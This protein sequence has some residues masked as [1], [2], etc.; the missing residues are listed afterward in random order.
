MVADW[1][2][3]II[4]IKLN[5]N[6]AIFVEVVDFIRL[7]C[8]RQFEFQQRLARFA[9]VVQ[10]DAA[11][12][13]LAGKGRRRRRD[14]QDIEGSILQAIILGDGQ[15]QQTEAAAD[16]QNDKDQER[17][18]AQASPLLAEEGLLIIAL[19]LAIWFHVAL[20]IRQDWFAPIMPLR[21]P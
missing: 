3:K 1:N 18:P 5:E 2:G 7:L 15:Q 8:E 13:V 20:T 16:C 17:Q 4:F 12:R 10:S 21:P 6:P 14:A 9:V 11:L 19:D